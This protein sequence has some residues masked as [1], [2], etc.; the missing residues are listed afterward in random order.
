[1]TNKLTITLAFFLLLGCNFM[2]IDKAS[3]WG[4]GKVVNGKDCS[5]FIDKQQKMYCTYDDHKTH[6]ANLKYSKC[7]SC[8]DYIKSL[9]SK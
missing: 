2:P 5:W 1:M 7:T 4:G 3:K 6:P 9:D 8:E